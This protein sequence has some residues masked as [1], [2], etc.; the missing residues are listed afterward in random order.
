M[1]ELSFFTRLLDDVSPGERFRLALEQIAHAEAH[2]Y[3]RAWVAQHHFRYAE[4]GLPSPFVFLAHAAAR[5]PRI[6]L[7]TGIVTL[8]LE[9]PIR[10]A[11]D[12]VV[13]SLLSDERIDLG[14]GSG[15]RP[16]SFVP[17][18]LDE[19]N[20]AADYNA[21]LDR[22][23]AVL[24]GK[25][26]GADNR[27][28]P[29]GE[30]VRS[31]IWQATFSATGGASAGQ[32]G[33]GLLLSKAQPR[34]PEFA[35]A[36]LADIQRPIIE[37]YRD[38]L[39]ADATPRITASRAVFVADSTADALSLA[40]GGLERLREFAERN[41]KR[42]DLSSPESILET[43]DTFVGD[44]DDVARL[45]EADETLRDADEVAIQV[46]SVDPAHE[47]IL[48]SIELVATEV[49]PRF[50]WATAAQPAFRH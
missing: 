32:N 29:G 23:H 26:L 24:D 25:D 1:T 37:A 40:H 39:A 15:T 35:N 7:A 34:T 19:S 4:G 8:T 33:N 12:A 36:T 41:G 47:H 46:H 5:V 48:R 50:G 22:L 27:L 10:V 14:I 2:G 44:P 20:K 42:I 43:T 6:R 3:A 9:D 21:K 38:A 16:A 17:F 45:L 30:S 49:A 13:A 28:Y 18:G 31:R 11:E